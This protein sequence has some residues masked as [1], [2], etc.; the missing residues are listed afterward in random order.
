MIQKTK[1]A[2]VNQDTCIGCNTCPIID[3][4][5][6]ELDQT[7]FK[8]KVKQPHTVTDLTKT[9]SD[10]CPVAAISIVEE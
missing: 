4:D 1:K 3:P 5:T 7:T 10:S 2:I 8:A 6:F 9:A